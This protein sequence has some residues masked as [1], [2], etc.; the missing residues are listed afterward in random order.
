MA[1]ELLR[2]VIAYAQTDYRDMKLVLQYDVDGIDN[3]SLY[4]CGQYGRDAACDV[5]LHELSYEEADECAHKIVGLGDVVGATFVFHAHRRDGLHKKYTIKPWM[6]RIV[7]DMDDIQPRVFLHE[8]PLYNEDPCRGIIRASTN[9]VEL[10]CQKQ[11]PSGDFGLVRWETAPQRWQ[12]VLRTPSV[13]GSQWM[14]GH[15][16]APL[17]GHIIRASQRGEWL[18]WLNPRTGVCGRREFVPDGQCGEGTC[19]LHVCTIT[20]RVYFVVR[21]CSEITT[22]SEPRPIHSKDCFVHPETVRVWSCK[23]DPPSYDLPTFHPSSSSVPNS[24]LPRIATTST[25]F[26]HVH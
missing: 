8:L 26:G 11:K 14:Y 4:V 15:V 13:L 5:R 17:E 12:P 16:G 3:R 2:I 23:F 1:A 18:L 6:C 19:R 10:Y 20:R 21:C 7:Y 9:D 22:Q 24:P 25:P